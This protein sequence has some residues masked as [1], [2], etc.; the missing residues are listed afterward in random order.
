MRGQGEGTTPLPAP[1]TSGVEQKQQQLMAAVAGLWERF[2]EPILGQVDGL[3]QAGSLQ[4]AGR[5]L[6]R[7]A[8]QQVAVIVLVYLGMDGDGMIQSHLAHEVRVV[9]DGHRAR[10]VG[11]EWVRREARDIGG[12]HMRR[13]FDQRAG[14]ARSS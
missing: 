12:E 13:V 8:V 3:E 1:G 7:E 11:A 9:L 4:V 6:V 14:G 10:F 2:K 5:R